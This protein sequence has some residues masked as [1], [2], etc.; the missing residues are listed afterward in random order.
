[1]QYYVLHLLQDP[2]FWGT[3][4]V[5]VILDGVQSQFSELVGHE[6]C[7]TVKEIVQVS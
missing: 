5:K 4:D 6:N 3:E 1:M 2:Y 7:Y